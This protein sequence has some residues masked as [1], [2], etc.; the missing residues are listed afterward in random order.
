VVEEPAMKQEQP[1]APQGAGLMA[2]GE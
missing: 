1:A 2:R